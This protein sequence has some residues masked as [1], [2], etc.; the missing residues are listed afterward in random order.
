VPY[1]SQAFNRQGRLYLRRDNG[2]ATL[3]PIGNSSYEYVTSNGSSVTAPLPTG[4]LGEE[5][6]RSTLAT[7]IFSATSN[8]AFNFYFNYVTLDGAGYTD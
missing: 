7:L 3:S 5:I 1:A 4:A 6:N 8:T 2:F